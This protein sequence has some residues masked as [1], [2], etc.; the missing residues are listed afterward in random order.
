MFHG[1]VQSAVSVNLFIVLIL[2]FLLGGATIWRAF[3]VEPHH[4]RT[5]IH[6]VAVP[7]WQ[8]G[9]ELRILQL[10][11]LHLWGLTDLH[12]RV[13]EQAAA[14]APDV[15]AVTG[16]YAESAD[17][18][19]ALAEL[20]AELGR[21]APVYAVMGDN[22]Q[23]NPEWERRLEAVFKRH[24]VSVLRNEAALISAGDATLVVVGTDDPN[25]GRSRVE[26]AEDEA[27]ALLRG[28]GKEG[29]LDSVYTVVLAHSPE[30]VNRAQPWMDLILTGHTHGGQIC[31]PG[32]KALYTN[33]PACRGYA[34]GMYRLA[35]GSRLYVHR[36]VGTARIP[37]R[38][39]CPP[40]VALFRLQGT[41]SHNGVA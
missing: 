39:F 4:P 40:E 25:T 9:T 34:S 29:G 8:A 14:L 3:C 7:H 21:I 19:Q 36:G 22:D 26:R 18:L 37:A 41:A 24:Q 38:L 20:M 16:D 11:D 27:L 2:V 6:T 28:K 31:L 17:G 30:I 35:G 12:R 1:S 15:I 10:S 32:G 13:L 33:T 23:E 5:Q